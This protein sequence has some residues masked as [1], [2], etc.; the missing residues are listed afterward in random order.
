MKTPNG[1]MALGILLYTLILAVICPVLRRKEKTA[2]ACILCLL[3]PHRCGGVNQN[4]G[5]YIYLTDNIT[6]YYPCFLSLSEDGTPFI[7]TDIT[8]ENRIPLDVTIPMT[9]ETALEIFSL[10][11]LFYT[12]ESDPEL[13]YA[14]EYIKNR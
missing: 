12:D 6:F 1:L 4:N 5:G 7:D 9:R 8:R 2:A 13:D 10:N 11:R 14:M 3:P